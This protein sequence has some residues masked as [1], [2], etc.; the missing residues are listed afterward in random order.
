MRDRPPRPIELKLL[1]SAFLLWSALSIAESVT[2]SGIISPSAGATKYHFPLDL[3]AFGFLAAIGLWK[4]SGAGR[5]FALVLT[6]YW[7][8]G[9]VLLFLE[10]FPTK[11]MKV[12]SNGDFL[13]AVPVNVL[14][15]F[16]VPFLIAQLWQLH[17]LT[18]PHIRALFRPP[19]FQAA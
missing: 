10:L 11:G 7:L 14:R 6:W 15:A 16:I 2:R 13:A 3:G 5:T 8:L 17:A 4:L 9:S 19:G 1:C 12:T 18:R